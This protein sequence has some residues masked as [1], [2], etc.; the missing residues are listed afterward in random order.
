MLGKEGKIKRS[1]LLVYISVLLL[2]VAALLFGLNI[3]LAGDVKT[4]SVEDVRAMPSSGGGYRSINNWKTVETT[5]FEGVSVC[6]LLDGCGVTDDGASI[7]IWAPDGYFWPALGDTLTVKELKKKGI[8]G[9]P[10]LIAYEMSGKALDP[11][12]DGTGP[13]RYVAPQYSIDDTNKPSWV[14]N[15]RLIEVGPLG[16][17]AKPPDAKKIPAGE[18]CVYGNIPPVYPISMMLPLAFGAA[19]LAVLLM[20]LITVIASR[21]SRRHLR[22]AVSALLAACL[23]AGTA[24]ALSGGTVR[25]QES[26]VFSNGELASMPAFSGHYTFLKQLPPYSYYETDYTGVPVSYLVNEKLRLAPGSSGVVIRARDGYAVTLSLEQVNKTYP[27][28]LKLIIAYAKGGQPLAGDEGPIRLIVPQNKQG[29]R[30]QGGDANT[31]LCARMIFAVEVTP[32]PAGVSVP[33]PGSVPS[34]SLAVYGSVT[35]P[36]PS[37]TPAPPPQAQPRADSAQNPAPAAPQPGQA[38]VT[39][40]AVLDLVN[41][42]FGGARGVVSWVAGSAFSF[43]LPGRAGAL[44]WLAFHRSGV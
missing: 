44:L 7:K 34:G 5:S 10:P 24:L 16:K 3:A 8:G 17:G 27:G 26:A 23:L 40:N 4:L 12:P 22:S 39:A 1:R 36:P 18:V 41:S 9:L 11:E 2:L 43:V 19:G 37:V 15:V 25:A 33:S 35:E 29:T 32:V 42:G 38:P 14:S 31:P 30:D 13:L 20:S 28:G 21:S 6:G